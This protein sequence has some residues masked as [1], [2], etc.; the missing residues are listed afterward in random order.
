M[1][2]QNEIDNK[3]W[4]IVLF[5]ILIGS[6]L[7]S[8]AIYINGFIGDLFPFMTSVNFSYWITYPGFKINQT[9]LNRAWPLG[10]LLRMLI[11]NAL[12]YAL[13]ITSDHFLQTK[14]ASLTVAENLRPY[15]LAQFI[16]FSIADLFRM[17]GDR[18]QEYFR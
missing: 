14:L 17:F 13:A 9:W 2:T 16:S 3:R 7:I 12:L 10:T 8:C 6:M 5:V 4:K 1:S 18:I 11:L 15:L